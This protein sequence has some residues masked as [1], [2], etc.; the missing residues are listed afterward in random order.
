MKANSARRYRLASTYFNSSMQRNNSYA[1]K[2]LFS[3]LPGMMRNLPPTRV[4]S[5]LLGSAPSNRRSPRRRHGRTRPARP[6]IPHCG[7]PSP[8]LV[9]HQPRPARFLRQVCPTLPHAAQLRSAAHRA[10]GRESDCQ[11]ASCRR[12]VRVGASSSMFRIP[13]S[14]AN[15]SIRHV[16]GRSCTAVSRWIRA[17]RSPPGLACP[18]HGRG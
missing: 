12:L 2:Q 8:G 15:V 5:D 14:C 11:W 4:T 16:A 13:P 1:A 7:N 18:C 17:C 9:L 3:F 6:P 10:P